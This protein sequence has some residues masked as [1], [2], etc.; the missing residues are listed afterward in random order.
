MSETTMPPIFRLSGWVLV[1]VLVVGT[2]MVGGNSQPIQVLVGAVLMAVLLL[3]P[4]PTRSTIALTPATSV[5]AALPLMKM[6]DGEF[7]LTACLATVMLGSALTWL[8]GSTRGIPPRRLLASSFRLLISGLSYVILFDVIGTRG[9]AR[10]EIVESGW[11]SDWWQVATIAIVTPIAFVTEM[12]TASTVRSP[13]SK[14]LQSR[15]PLELRDF[16]VY[17]VLVVTG[18]LLG[19]TF[20]DIG[21]IA[22]VVAGVPFMLA[23]GSFR[24]LAD[25][26]QTYT[27][28]VRAMAQI[29][30]AAGHVSP[31]HAVRVARLSRAVANY[32]GLDPKT[33]ERVSWASYLHDIGRI[34]L[35]DPGVA[36]LGYTEADIAEWGAVIVEEA[37]LSDV[38]QVIRV[39]HEPYRRP[40]Q[41][42]DPDLPIEARIIKAASAY[43]DLVGDG[44]HSP[45]EALEA[46][47]RGSVYDYDPDIIN[48]M[49][50]ILETRGAMEEG[51]ADA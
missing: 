23:Y 36:R 43:D 24:R 3:V 17:L 44:S 47:Y 50:T 21:S 10:I 26:R 45:L 14:S 7:G 29:P 9:L 2:L 37:T 31:G 11:L 12:F 35:N 28:T 41:Q 13:A 39:Q 20:T 6:G 51:D 25:T 22:L 48:A 46:L 27:E 49:R 38:A 4:V 16:D 32:L 34:S 42:A 5:V 19:L 30:E 18:A 15:S 33:A 1:G 40:G 8:V